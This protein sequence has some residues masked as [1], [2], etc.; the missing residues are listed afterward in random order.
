MRIVNLTAVPEK[1]KQS[2]KGKYHSFM[3]E[4]SVALGRE[5]LI[6]A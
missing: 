1:E 3:K 5:P 6:L 2:P 4:A